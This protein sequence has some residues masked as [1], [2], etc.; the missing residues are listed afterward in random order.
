MTPT[1]AM[2]DQFCETLEGPAGCNFHNGPKGMQWTCTSRGDRKLSK[3]ILKDMGADV[4]K[5]LKY[6]DEHGG[7][8]D[9]EILFNVKDGSA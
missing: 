1:H 3:A 8:C 4:A 6:F 2:W 5:S 9:C 7:H